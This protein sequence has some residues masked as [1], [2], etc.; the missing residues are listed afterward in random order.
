[1]SSSRSNRSNKSNK[2]S[3]SNRSTG[4]SDSVKFQKKY[5]NELKV[6]AQQMTIKKLKERIENI[7][8]IKREY[9]GNENVKQQLNKQIELLVSIR[10]N[11]KREYKANHPMHSSIAHTFTKRF[12]NG[13][14]SRKNKTNRKR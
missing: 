3:K 10:N 12:W 8:S 9:E 14:K 2:S 1:M 5:L 13:G 7:E 11:K 4:L 6:E